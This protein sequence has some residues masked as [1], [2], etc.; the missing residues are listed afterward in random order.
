[1][2]M[3]NNFLRIDGNMFRLG[4]NAEEIIIL[5]KIMEFHYNTGKVFVSNDTFAE[6]CGCS[7]KTVDRR[8][9]HLEE[10]GLIIRDTKTSQKGKERKILFQEAKYLEL[11]KG[12]N[13]HC[14]N[15][16][17]NPMDKLSIAE[18][19]KCLLPNGQN[20]SIKEN[21]KE[22]LEIEKF[23]NFQQSQA[24]VET[25]LKSPEVV[26]EVKPEEEKLLEVSMGKI[27]QIWG[28][29]NV[30]INDNI[31]SFPENHSNYGKRFKL[32]EKTAAE[33]VI[34]KKVEKPV[35]NKSKFSF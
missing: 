28:L 5:A 6:L 34:V 32:V 25:S 33:K 18:G 16:N 7:V 11:A 29:D 20:D 24:P 21:R 12:Q 27:K 31:V 10:L 13:V 8:V 2:N 22:K 17:S 23:E 1:M 26:E 15:T 35:E 30:I 4:L 3:Y 19:T 9:K 14:E